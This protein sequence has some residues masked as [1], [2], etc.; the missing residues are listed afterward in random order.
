M[1]VDA[2]LVGRLAY[3][4]W[5]CLLISS[6]I[7]LGPVRADTLIGEGVL[8]ARIDRGISSADLR[9]GIELGMAPVEC[10]GA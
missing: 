5:Q 10:V 9:A 2:L 4:E 8:V 6:R 7:R 1:V 3:V